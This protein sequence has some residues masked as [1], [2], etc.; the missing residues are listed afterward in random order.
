MAAAKCKKSFTECDNQTSERETI[1]LRLSSRSEYDD[2]PLNLLSI[3]RLRTH[4]VVPY[5]CNEIDASF[6]AHKLFLI[7][8]EYAMPPFIR[9]FSLCCGFAWALPAVRCFPV[10]SAAQTKMENVH[11]NG[12]DFA[13]RKRKQRN[14][15]Y[16]DVFFSLRS[17]WTRS[18]GIWFELQIRIFLETSALE[19]WT[20]SGRER[21]ERQR[22]RR[23]S[24][25][26]M[27]FRKSASSSAENQKLW[28]VARRW[29]QSQPVE[30]NFHNKEGSLDWRIERRHKVNWL[31]RQGKTD[32]FCVCVPACQ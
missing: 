28:V 5:I 18:S 1:E 30:M 26:L 3:I 22:E 17:P 14:K 13:E 11:L 24:E 23:K 8:S 10:A 12:F 19:R 6:D 16:I 4:S 27:L 31:S 7:Y 21:A 2:L 20:V 29:H 9:S 15:F 32:F 25:L